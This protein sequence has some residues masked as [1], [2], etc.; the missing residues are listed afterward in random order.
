[1]NEAGWYG[2]KY[3]SQLERRRI[4]VLIAV[5]NLFSVPVQE[6]MWGS[7]GP[8]PNAMVGSMSLDDTNI[9]DRP[10]A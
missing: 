4:T 1:L 8:Q 6:G 10:V 2:A 9:S 7:G 3:L 5:R